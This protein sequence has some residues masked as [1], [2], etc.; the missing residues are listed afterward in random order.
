[1]VTLK[2]MFIK[3]LMKNVMFMCMLMFIFE[4]LVLKVFGFHATAKLTRSPSAAWF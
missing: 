3:M 2:I 4:C 1:M